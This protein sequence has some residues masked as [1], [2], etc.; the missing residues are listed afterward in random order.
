MTARYLTMWAFSAALCICAHSSADEPREKQPGPNAPKL[1]PAVDSL[2][3]PL[4]D[5]AIRRLG[6]VRFRGYFKIVVAS[7]DGKWFASTGGSVAWLWDAATG[8][9]VRSFKVSDDIESLTF[10]PDS[11]FLITGWD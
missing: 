4:P 7:P 2:G 3:D 10:T 8:K 1:A 11:K 9:R 5:G 6:T